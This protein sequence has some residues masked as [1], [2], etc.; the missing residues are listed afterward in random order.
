MQDA[1]QQKEDPPR[2]HKWSKDSL[3]TDPSKYELEMLVFRPLQDPIEGIAEPISVAWLM[4]PYANAYRHGRRV[5]DD[6]W[7]MSVWVMPMK[8][9]R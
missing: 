2:K 7:K 1:F 3:R 9:W 5:E 4:L 6:G 8:M